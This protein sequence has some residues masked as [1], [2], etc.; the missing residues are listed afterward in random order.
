M[1]CSMKGMRTISKNIHLVKRKC[2]AS[3]LRQRAPHK[4]RIG[5]GAHEEPGHDRDPSW[6]SCP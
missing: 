1:L 5:L 2:E 3:W 4:T 6:L